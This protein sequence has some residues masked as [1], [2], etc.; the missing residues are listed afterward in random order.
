MQSNEK[1][2]VLRIISRLNIGGPSIHS[3]LLSKKINFSA[4]EPHLIFG[5]TDPLEGNLAPTKNEPFQYYY[6]PHLQR[7]ISP[8]RDFRSFISILKIIKKVKPHIVHTHQAK[9]GLLGR[10]AAIVTGVPIRIHTFHGHVFH[11]Y[12][13]TWKT[14]LFLFLERILARYS[15]LIAISDNQKQELESHLK[16]PPSIEVIPLGLELKKFENLPPQE[17]LKKQ[18]GYTQDSV[19]IGIVG[20]LVPI[21]NHDLFLDVAKELKN[22]FHHVKFLIVGDGER[23]THLEKRIQSENLDHVRM[24]GW[25]KDLREIYS[26]LD[27]VVLTSLN[28]GTP[29]SLIEAAA[30]GKS[31]VSVCVGGVDSIIQHKINGYLIQ[32]HNISEFTNSLEQLIKNKV[33][34]EAMGKSLQHETIKYF[35]EDRLI[36]K[37]EDLYKKTSSKFKAKH[38]GVGGKNILP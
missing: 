22:Q 20:R 19:I 34:R 12:F 30:S 23:R 35:G 25:Q 32:N 36:K 10:L 24:I 37:I 6:V 29:V 14:N 33:L 17:P 38:R 7:E 21:K 11:S 2:R 13:P 9:A 3:L 15:H 18:W 4:F 8:F 26:L 27:I 28:E 16:S 5:K 1:I 31:I